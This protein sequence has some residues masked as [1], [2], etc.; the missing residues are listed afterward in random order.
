[1]AL[2]LRV[3]SDGK[4]V[5]AINAKTILYLNETATT[6]VYYFMQGMPTEKAAHR[7]RST[8]RVSEETARKDHER[9]IYAISTLAQT[10]E[11]C[12]ISY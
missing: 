5:L 10:Q 9:L 8:Y 7:I 12:P 2:Q 11:V 1:M 6:H 4:G 3:E